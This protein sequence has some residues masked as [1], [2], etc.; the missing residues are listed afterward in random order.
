MSS[1]GGIV[2]TTKSGR[3]ALAQRGRAL[4]APSETGC[5]PGFVFLGGDCVPARSMFTPG[6]MRAVIGRQTA[7][8][9]SVVQG[10]AR[11]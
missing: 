10:V 4:S 11:G 1:A 3:E 8:R 9:R 6:K 7:T 2:G 5:P